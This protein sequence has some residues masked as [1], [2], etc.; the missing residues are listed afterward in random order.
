MTVIKLL[1]AALLLTTAI[2]AQTPATTPAPVAQVYV[3]TTKGIYLYN[4]STTGKLTLVS[5]KAYT[6]PAGL[7]VGVSGKYL[8]SVG[9]YIVHSYQLSST[10]TIGGKLSQINT[11]TYYNGNCGGTFNETDGLVSLNPQGR[12]VYVAFP[13]ITGDCDAALQTFNLSKT[14]ILSFNANVIV[15]GNAGDGLEQIPAI[16]AR[17]T[18]AYAASDFS[19]CGGDPPSWSGFILASNGEM[20][21]WTFNLSGYPSG[22]DLLPAWYYPF[23][24]TADPTNHLAALVARNT[25]PETYSPLQLASYTVDAHGDLTT[26][27][28]A[29]NMPT[30]IVLETNVS[31]G[32]FPAEPMNMSPSGKLLAVG[33]GGGLE[34]YHFNGASPITPYSKVLTTA[35]IDRMRWDNNKHLFALSD[36]THKLYVFTV[37]PTT[38]TQVAGSPFTI[39]TGTPNALVVVPK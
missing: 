15:G 11:H 4:A 33:S 20:Q 5:S 14:G 10:G 29:A 16:L 1:S 12:N 26:T 18:F 38:I 37:T 34:I 35:E 13:V 39:P 3:G 19:C 31:T 8:I 28:T 9:T 2:F 36:L 23:Y 32:G 7:L 30:P 6:T 24:V 21:N 25:D 22:L 17:D 27:S